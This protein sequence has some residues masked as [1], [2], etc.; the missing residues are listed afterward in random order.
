MEQRTAQNDSVAE[1]S[2]SDQHEEQFNIFKRAIETMATEQGSLSDDE[3]EEDER[4]DDVFALS[5]DQDQKSQEG[6]G[7]KLGGILRMLQSKVN[8]IAKEITSVKKVAAREERKRATFGQVPKKVKLAQSMVSDIKSIAQ[9]G[10]KSQM[11]TME[12]AM[13][14]I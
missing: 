6:G 3:D 14:I 4:L 5:F 9:M 8:S 7:S 10:L 1:Y 2:S 13:H 12:Q 11:V